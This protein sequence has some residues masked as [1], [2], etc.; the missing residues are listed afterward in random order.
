MKN[1]SKIKKKIEFKDSLSGDGFENTQTKTSNEQLCPPTQIAIYGQCYN[2]LSDLVPNS[3]QTGC[4]PCPPG[5]IPND[6]RFTCMGEHILF[7]TICENK[8]RFKCHIKLY[9]KRLEVVYYLLSTYE[10]SRT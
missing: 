9:V 10:G 8:D 6:D 2:C 5:Q 1:A 3:D 4:V 7:L